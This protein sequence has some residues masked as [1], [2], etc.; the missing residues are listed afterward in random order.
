MNV[1]LHVGKIGNG[2]RIYRSPSDNAGIVAIVN[3]ITAIEYVPLDNS[4]FAALWWNGGKRYV[5]KSA[6]R[7]GH[8]ITQDLTKST[9]SS[10]S[11]SEIGKVVGISIAGAGGYVRNK[12]TLQLGDKIHVDEQAN[13][14][15]RYLIPMDWCEALPN[16][17][18]GLLQIKIESFYKIDQKL[19]ESLYTR[20]IAVPEELKPSLNSV[21]LSPNNGLVPAE[22]GYREKI[23]KLSYSIQADSPYGAQI[24]EYSLQVGS[25]KLEGASGESPLFPNTG[26]LEVLCRVRDSRGRESTQTQN[27]EVLPYRLPNAGNVQFARCLADGTLHREGE[28]LKFLGNTAVTEGFTKTVRLFVD[29]VERVPTGEIYPGFTLG[30]SHALRLVVSDGYHSSS[31]EY[32]LDGGFCLLNIRQNAVAIGGFAEE[33][34]VFEVYYPLGKNL[35]KS[36]AE[37]LYAYHQVTLPAFA[38]GHSLQLAGV[39]GRDSALIDL[40]YNDNYDADYDEFE[41]I[42]HAECVEGSIDFH[43]VR[44]VQRELHL[45]ILLYKNALAA[46]QTGQCI[47]QRG[48]AL[49]KRWIVF[50]TTETIATWKESNTSLVRN[51]I[52]IVSDFWTD[53][54]TMTAFLIQADLRKYNTLCFRLNIRAVGGG[55]NYRM[56]CGVYH[57]GSLG[58]GTSHSKFRRYLTPNTSA[59]EQVLRVNVSDYNATYPIGCFGTWRGTVKEIWLE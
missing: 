58:A 1:S 49:P 14:N 24:Q 59:N 4:A 31:Y 2:T 57:T 27:I 54:N 9:A 47:L 25:F 6:I 29:E 53:T 18:Q 10:I 8:T 7:D 26:V 38:E 39:T 48:R 12:V 37:S 46:G 41:K 5:L 11:L 42:S 34:N 40:V 17:G 22:K 36:L 30:R 45:K 35:K 32:Q 21:E 50:P 55:D 33:D 23:G 15:F 28:Y 3:P 16:A 19:G 20:N 56:R 13:G 43:S 44:E 52:E 51:N